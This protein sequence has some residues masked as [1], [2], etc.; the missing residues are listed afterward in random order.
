MIRVR[1]ETS[2]LYIVFD[3]LE[4]GL[5]SAYGLITA[6]HKFSSGPKP[7]D[8]VG[9][10]FIVG[11]RQIETAGPFSLRL[12]ALIHQSQSTLTD[13]CLES[14]VSLGGGN[15]DLLGTRMIL[16]AL[17]EWLTVLQQQEML[18]CSPLMGATAVVPLSPVGISYRVQISGLCRIRLRHKIRRS[19]LPPRVHSQCY[20]PVSSPTQVR[21]PSDRQPGIPSLNNL[22]IHKLIH[23]RRR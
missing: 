15:S 17:M 11:I 2:S 7:S 6:K 9:I 22:V 8:A 16:S 19:N 4:K 23:K 1:K 10:L 5:S 21:Q 13:F 3:R 18:H 12:E 14:K 20:G